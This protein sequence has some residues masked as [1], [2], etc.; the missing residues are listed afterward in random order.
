MTCFQWFGTYKYHVHCLD[1]T[2][3]LFLVLKWYYYYYYYYY[4]NY[5]Y[6]YYYYYYTYLPVIFCTLLCITSTFIYLFI[7]YLLFIYLFICRHICGVNQLFHWPPFHPD[8]FRQ[9][10]CSTRYLNT[11]THTHRPASWHLNGISPSSIL[12]PA[13]STNQKSK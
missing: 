3:V 1:F 6:Y 9:L 11:H 4:Y 12:P 10:S 2:S 13:S 8:F 5:Y 7:I